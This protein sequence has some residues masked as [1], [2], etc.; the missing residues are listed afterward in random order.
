LPKQFT[1]TEF[2]SAGLSIAGPV[3]EDN[4]DSILVPVKNAPSLAG[5]LHAVADGMGGYANGALASSLAI[6]H[7]S[8]F[9][10]AS[11][12][13]S[14]ASKILRQAFDLVN[15]EVYKTSQ[16]LDN[17]RMG[18]TLTAAYITGNVLSLLHIGDSRAYLIRHEKIS[19]LT[20]DHTNVGEMVRSHL[21][22]ADHVRTHEQRS[23]LTRAIGL[24]L[25]AQPDLSQ[26]NLQIGDRIILCSDGVWAVIEDQLFVEISNRSR[27]VEMLAQN[28]LDLAVENNT[29]DNCS[30]VAIQ[31]RGF[32][33]QTFEE[34]PGKE[35]GWLDLFRR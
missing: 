6:Q 34:K 1:L 35:R 31:I 27:S 3:R 26:I 7:L 5:H 22:P 13:S 16:Q 17:I 21:I 32:R 20:Q 18:T 25:F 15:F 8:K 14:P 23:I 29:D 11:D 30:V 19:C 4:Q 12:I 9:I 28:L 2:D 10:R 33:Y 24:T